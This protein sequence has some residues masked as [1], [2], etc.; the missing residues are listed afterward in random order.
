MKQELKLNESKKERDYR[1]SKQLGDFGE[2][3]VVFLLGSIKKYKVALV[4][5]EGADIIA[6]DRE[7][8]GKKYAI[9]VKSRRFVTDDPSIAFDSSNQKKLRIFSEEFDMIPAVAF[10]MMDSKCE[11]IEVYIITLDKLEELSRSEEKNGFSIRKDKKKRTITKN[12]EK[13]KEE[14]F[15]ESFAISNASKNKKV[16]QDKEYIDYTCINISK[17]TESL[18]I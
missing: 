17:F 10:T 8:G 18:K 12:N 4:D 5:H 14:Y 2:N 11:N 6:T 7:D 1:L 9:S 15:E 3:L 16:L 13:I